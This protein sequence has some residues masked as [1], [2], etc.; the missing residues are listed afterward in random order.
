MMK[1]ETVLLDFTNAY[2]SRLTAETIAL[3]KS[4]IQS[5]LNHCNEAYTNVT[6]KDIRSWMKEMDSRGIR[7]TTIYT[8]LAA[9]KTFYRY[10]LE[11]GLVEK[12][13]TETIPLPARS[14]KMPY[15]L[16]IEQLTKLRSLLDHRPEERAI[17]EVLYATGIRVRELA[18]IKKEDI[19]WTERMIH[20]RNGK[21]KKDR[22]VLFTK[23]CA[24][25]MQRYLNGRTDDV[26]YLFVNRNK[27]GPVVVRTIQLRFEKYRE[28][29][30]FHISPHTLRH[31]FAAQ[32][33]RKGM[34][35][36]G[37]QQLLGHVSLQQSQLYARLYSHARKEIYD[38]IM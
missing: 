20:V 12:D 23:V 8:K 32:L 5:M 25:S 34:S 14:E 9:L 21:G 13:P 7:P 4:A 36:S 15:Y 26:P 22:I 28:Q 33:A 18:A 24:E 16:E 27:N 35:L 38:E 11:D 19:N 3:Y 6:K 2:S 1:T 10:C 17:M 30:G 31:T 37:I 29:L